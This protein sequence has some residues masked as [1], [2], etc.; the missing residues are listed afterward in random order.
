M[1][2]KFRTISE[3]DLSI[4]VGNDFLP[5]AV[6]LGSDG[7]SLTRGAVDDALPLK[8]LRIP[9][10]ISTKPWPPAS[11]TPA[12]LRTGRSSGVVAS[13]F[14]ALSQAAL[15]TAIASAPVFAVR[16][17]LSEARRA[18]VRIVPSVGF[19]TAPVGHLYTNLKRIRKGDA[20]HLP[21]TF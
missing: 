18:T 16:L 5:L 13:A 20:I 6:M 2:Q 7:G 12:F 10:R 14:A 17:A 11:T 1:D 8:T 9:S 21:A 15:K 3:F 4:R 19:I